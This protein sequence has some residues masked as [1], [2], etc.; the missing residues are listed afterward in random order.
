LENLNR[1]ANEHGAA[2]D[3]DVQ[4]RIHELFGD[5]CCTVLARL[6]KRGTLGD[7]SDLDFNVAEFLD[8]FEVVKERDARIRELIAQSVESG[9]QGDV[10]GG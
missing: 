7:W 2:N 9:V 10:D 4:E 6:A 3:H 8:G 5:V 1:L